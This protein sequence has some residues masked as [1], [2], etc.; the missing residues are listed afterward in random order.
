MSPVNRTSTI[1]GTRVYMA[2][3]I[4]LQGGYGFLANWWSLG[5]MIFEMHLGVESFKDLDDPQ[6]TIRQIVEKELEFPTKIGP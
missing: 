2:L 5:I 4:L 6:E 3:E 1:Y